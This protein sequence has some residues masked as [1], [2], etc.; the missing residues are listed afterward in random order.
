MTEREIINGCIKKDE[1]CQ[2]M[3]F[4]QF[5]AGMM[6]VCRR[7][8]RDQGEAEDILQDAFIRIFSFIR[9]YRSEGS[10]EGW[11]RRIVVNTALKA[12]QKRKI[13]FSG[14]NEEHERVQSTEAD[15]PSNLSAEELLKL[16]S[17]LPDGYRLVFNLYVM[18]EYNHEEIAGMLKITAGTSRSQ[19]S[20]ARRM[21]KEQI[22]SIQKIPI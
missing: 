12:I 3:L 5:A 21:L 6:T 10:L 14:I 1:V 7:Y 15:A 11:I 4:E 18:E 20:K 16:I 2:R 19:L 22:L 8:A 9:Q 17:Q 13:V